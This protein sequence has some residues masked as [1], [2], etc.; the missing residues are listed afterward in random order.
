MLFCGITSVSSRLIQGEKTKY[1]CDVGKVLNLEQ[2][3]DLNLAPDGQKSISVGNNQRSSNSYN[4]YKRFR[5]R[6]KADRGT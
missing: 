1:F 2:K 4:V 3:Q 6:L 5:F